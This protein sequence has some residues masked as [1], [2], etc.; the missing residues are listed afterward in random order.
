MAW[1]KAENAKTVAVLERDPRYPTL[2]ADALKLAESRDRIP[3]P[4][5]I[6]GEVYN[7][8]QDAEHTHGVWRRTTLASYRSASPTWTTVLD[9]DALSR[10]EKANWFW[11]GASC[12]EPAEQRCLISLSDGGEDAVTV[13]EF[14][15]PSA[16]FVVG[17]FT[18]PHGKQN[19][20]WENANTI[21]VAREWAPG[22]MTKSGYAYVV[23]RLAR[24][25]PLSAA[26]EVF[27]GQPS[28]VSAGPFTL[29]DGDGHQATLVRR[30]PSFFENEYSIETPRG[31][32]KLAVPLKAS[33]SELVR[34]QLVI[35]L[36]SPWTVD[37]R[38]FSAGSVVSV[39]LSAVVANPSALT[40]TLDRRAGRTRGDRADVGDA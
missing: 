4:T 14:D 2:Y 35:G 23:K 1:V 31:F 25:Q 7:F 33:V 17:G 34:G 11:K 8:W 22:E 5:I 20:A 13:R 39:P 32:E 10:A 29:H 12:A 19:V 38:T 15:L 36:N 37:G 27:R 40:P 18:L 21:L 3:Y 24:G 28:D 6:G 26:V 30:G 9:L 16:S